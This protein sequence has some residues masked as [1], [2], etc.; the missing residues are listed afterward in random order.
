MSFFLFALKISDKELETAR[1]AGNNY[2]S[3]FSDNNIRGLPFVVKVSTVHGHGVF[4]TKD[5]AIGEKFE[6]NRDDSYSLRYINDA[7][8]F[9]SNTTSSRKELAQFYQQATL[10]YERNSMAKANMILPET[11]EYEYPVVEFIKE[12]KEGE[13]LFQHYGVAAWIVM[14]P[15]RLAGAYRLWAW[16]T[17][18]KLFKK[19]SS[20]KKQAILWIIIHFLDNEEGDLLSNEL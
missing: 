19:E 14:E 11:E 15:G 4:A 20:W 6:I 9:P 8:L 16:E 2:A 10:E 1:T 13:E 18:P 7:V 12:V 5:I 3:K 17:L